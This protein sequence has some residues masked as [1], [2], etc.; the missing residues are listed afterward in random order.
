MGTDIG[1]ESTDNEA[2]RRY[3]GWEDNGDE[4]CITSSSS[5]EEEEVD[6][7][8]RI[9]D[10]QNI[11]DSVLF[12]SFVWRGRGSLMAR[13][14]AA[15]SRSSEPSI[16]RTVAP[17][18]VIIVF[19]VVHSFVEAHVMFSFP[20]LALV[21]KRT[22]AT[23]AKV[24]KS[25]PETVK[26]TYDAG[27]ELEE[28]VARMLKKRGHINIKM[29]QRVKDKNGNL[30]EFDIVYGWPVRHYVECK[31]YSHPVKLEMVAKFKVKRGRGAL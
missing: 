19:W 6:L 25:A 12:I 13:F 16:D 3:Y 14:E 1:M 17:S 26:T 27:K 24:E 2:I 4:E 8:D 20:R 9:L 5:S 7:E 28:R 21:G 15:A 23:A 30:S 31:N 29:N 11:A 18:S 10:V 22:L